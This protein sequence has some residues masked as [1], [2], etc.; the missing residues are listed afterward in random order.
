M[1]K[2]LETPPYLAECSIKL[3]RNTKFAGSLISAM[4]YIKDTLFKMDA[5]GYTC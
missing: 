5:S 3:S 4:S 2:I 1:P